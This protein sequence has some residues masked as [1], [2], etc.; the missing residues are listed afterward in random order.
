MDN[1]SQF[2]LDKCMDFA[3]RIVNLY[4]YLKDEKHVLILSKQLLRSGTSIGA[5][6]AEATNAISHADFTAKSSIALKETTETLY[7]IELLHRSTYLSEQQYNS[8][9]QD[10]KELISIL[11]T[12]LKKL[13]GDN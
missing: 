12:S 4:N 13:K 2:F 5:N 9:K 3:V 6:Y 11:T 8:I 1:F 10:I 7:W